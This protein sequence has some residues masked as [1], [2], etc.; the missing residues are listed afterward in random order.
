MNK[1][2]EKILS[3]PE[4]IENN[5]K[6]IHEMKKESNLLL[7]Y[8]QRIGKAKNTVEPKTTDDQLIR[9]VNSDHNKS[10]SSESFQKVGNHHMSTTG[11]TVY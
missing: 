9:L 1:N 5:T 6:Q 7:L 11:Y 3:S 4:E 2:E 10:S 8:R